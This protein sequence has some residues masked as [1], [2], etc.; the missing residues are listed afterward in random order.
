MKRRGDLAV[1]GIV[2]V[3]V[4]NFRYIWL[5]VHQHRQGSE[6]GRGELYLASD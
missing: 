1:S 3:E 5:F 2:R 4:D 6:E